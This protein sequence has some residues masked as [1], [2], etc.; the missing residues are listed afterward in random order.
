MNKVKWIIF[1]VVVV[2]IFGGI[3]W[4]NKS[5]EVKFTGDATKI[6]TE[7]IADHIKGTQEQKVTL[8]EYGDFQ[9]P[10]CGSIYPTVEEITEKYKDKVTFIFRNLPLTN[11]HPNALAAATA[12]EA[13]GKQGKYFDMYDILFQSQSSWSTASVGDRG[14]LFENYAAQIGLNVDQ[15]KSDLTSK[16]I[17]E[18]INRDI[19]TGK[20]TFKA[21]STPTFILN[22]QKI[23]VG[24]LATAVD[25]AVKA[26]YP[27][28]KQE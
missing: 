28:D 18:K 12:A 1:A 10:G 3:I 22:G 8:I 24:N 13:A 2:A 16:D 15:Y 4:L 23:E 11:I 14:K 25:D 6:I 26:A 17:T 21:S 19:A 7:G 20:G 5:N 9:C 27:D